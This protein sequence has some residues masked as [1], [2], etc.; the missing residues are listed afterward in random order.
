MRP[1]YIVHA[2]PFFDPATRFGGPIA[3]LRRTCRGLA[4]RGHDVRVV[5]TD[6]DIGPDLPRERWLERDGYRIWYAPVGRLGRFAPYYAPRARPPLLEALRQAQVLHLA[7]SFTH[8]NVLGRRLARTLDV[9]YV[10]TPRACL[11]PVRL[12]Q[13]HVSKRLFTSLF[14]RTVIRDAAAIHVLTRAERGHALAQGARPEQCVIIPNG[15]ELDEHTVFPDGSI[16]RRHCNIHRDAPL[17]LFMSRLHRIKGLDI[18]VDAFAGARQHIP[19]AQL[20]IAGPDEGIRRTIENRARQLGIAKATHFVGRL[21]GAL[22]LA[23]LRAA[24]LFA[25]TSYSEGLPNAV[26]DACA[27]A[28]P[29]LISDGCHVP[30]VATYRAGRVVGT[31]ARDVSIALREMLADRR[32]LKTMGEHAQR[33][34]RERFAFSDT[35]DRLERMYH[36]LAT[37]TGKTAGSA[38]TDASAIRAA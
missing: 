19:S 12:R 22:R 17:V 13:R 27:A 3:Q 6:L 10:Y 34:V 32:H 29:V 31:C 28:T 11:D 7:L 1:L 8:M 37:R 16:F 14:E 5:A 15:A 25:L 9:P 4:D 36:H 26:L 20:V 38:N 23:A 18:L 2:L 24:D 33:M 30:E 35:I 21:D